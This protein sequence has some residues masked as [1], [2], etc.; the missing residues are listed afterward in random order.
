MHGLA[1]AS[2]ISVIILDVVVFKP[3]IPE[4]QPRPEPEVTVVLRPL[5]L[6]PKVQPKPKPKTK[7]LAAAEPKPTPQPTPPKPDAVKPPP[8]PP[9][10]VAAKP[11][12]TKPEARKPLPEQKHRFARTSEDQAGKPDAPTDILGERDTTAASEL[13]SSNPNAPNV[14]NQDGVKPLR[15][16]HIETVDRSHIEGSVGM[17]KTGADTETPQEATARKDSETIDQAPI[18]EVP[19]PD[20]GSSAKPK[21]KHLEEGDILPSTDG[22][23]GKAAIQDKPKRDEA[24]KEKPNQG[25]KN[26]GRGDATQQPPKK[27]G[28]RGLSRKT[29]VTGSISRSGKSSLNVKNSPLGRYQALISKSVELQWRRKC[30][31]QR[32]HIVLGVVSVRFY[33]DEKGKVSGV[34]FQEVIGA[35]YIMTGFTQRAIRQAKLPK[36][37]TSVKKELKG[38]PLEL[39]YNFYF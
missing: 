28:F 39:I 38:E 21:N 16:G 25:S 15:P 5:E 9:P 32:D 6:S 12:E 17:D 35:S 4:K 19:K 23:E 36:M 20:E 33:V 11:K 30:V 22:G 1:L 34:K 10:S 24:P 2:W 26:D 18:L 29:K 37:S 27:D 13:P 8:P 7:P 3:V 14:P 31:E